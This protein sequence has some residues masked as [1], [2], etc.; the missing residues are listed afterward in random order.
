MH[1]N[2][3]KSAYLEY[4]KNLK[5]QYQIILDNYSESDKICPSLGLNCFIVK[6]EEQITDITISK[7]NNVDERF[8]STEEAKNTA[9]EFL[10][11]FIKSEKDS[12]IITESDFVTNN[13]RAATYSFKKTNDGS[14]FLLIDF[15]N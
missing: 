6:N 9:K 2:I 5:D 1:L 4:E 12:Q 11:N 7:L 13:L 14:Y 3:G 8:D 10:E 15:I